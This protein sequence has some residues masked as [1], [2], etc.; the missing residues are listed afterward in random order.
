MLFLPLSLA[1]LA[2]APSASTTETSPEIAA[3]QK[4][5]AGTAMVAGSF[6]QTRRWAA[7]R[8]SLVTH[9]TFQ[10][11][12][13]GKMTWRTLPPAE[14]ELV[15]EGSQATMRYPALGTT[16]SFDFGGDPGMAAVFDCIAA[17]LRADFEK[18]APQFDVRVT[19]REPLGV[20][21]KPRSTELAKVIAGIELTFT[22]RND[23]ARVVLYEGGGD[24]TEISFKDQVATKG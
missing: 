3:L 2:A 24:Q 19:L 4:K 5:L 8:D 21:L 17:V 20:S 18:L 14:S 12:R 23:L 10:W 7:L 11:T 13:G 6:T 22:A 1:L 16:Q 15:V 9:G